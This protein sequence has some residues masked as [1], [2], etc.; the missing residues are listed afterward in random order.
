[1]TTTVE[2][3]SSLTV[4]NALP[5]DRALFIRRTYLHLA[6]A[7]AAF[8]VLEYLLLSSPFAPAMVQFIFGS[9]YMWLMILGGLAVV[10]RTR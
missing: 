4:T 7:V 8:I 2:R 10:R 6:G 1:M 5:E 3:V 9:R